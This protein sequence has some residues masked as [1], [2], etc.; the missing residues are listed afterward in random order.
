MS[1]HLAMLP[2]SICISS[3]MI[4]QLVALGKWHYSICSGTLVELGAS[5]T[6]LERQS[7]SIMGVN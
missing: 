2:S 6:V 1:T 5:E 4:L 3:S 7:L